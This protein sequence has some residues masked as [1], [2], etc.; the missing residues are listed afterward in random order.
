[1]THA[2]LLRVTRV[3]VRLF[4]LAIVSVIASSCDSK[5]QRPNRI[6]RSNGSIL[7]GAM[8]DTSDSLRTGPSGGATPDTATFLRLEC[9]L[10]AKRDVE[11]VAQATGLLTLT[12]VNEGDRVAANTV[13]ARIDEVDQAADAA[14]TEAVRD[15]LALAWARAQKLREGEAIS[16]ESWATARS[17]WQIAEARWQRAAAALMRCV[18]RTPIAG[19]VVRSVVQRGQ[20]VEAG[21]ILFRVCD[22][23]ELCAE[24]LVPE[25][26]RARIRRGDPVRVVPLGGLACTA[27]ISRIGP[28]VDPTTSSF[29]VVIDV[30]NAGWRL[31]PGVSAEVQIPIAGSLRRD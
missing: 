13:L 6:A 22:P 7:T 3:A 15:R 28:I 26:E 27:R 19:V 21:A 20:R 1:M 16:E 9:V 8:A 14:E 18:V 12:R 24:V 29:R 17:E 10:L 5:S 4:V 23:S 31:P 2:W 30:E 11:I 25:S